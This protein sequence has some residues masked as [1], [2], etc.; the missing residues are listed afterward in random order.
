MG[1]PP[2]DAML[3]VYYEEDI[4]AA[5]ENCLFF[6]IN[7][8]LGSCQNGN[9]LILYME[10]FIALAGTRRRVFLQGGYSQK[11]GEGP[12]SFLS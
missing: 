9:I 8:P 11:A 1:S 10:S 12:P 3:E 7:R 6:L 2:L 5:W 4:Q